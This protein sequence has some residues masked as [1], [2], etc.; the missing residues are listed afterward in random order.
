MEEKV[1]RNLSHILCILCAIALWMYVIYTEDPEMQVWMRGIPI[2]YQGAEAMLENGITFTLTEEPEEVNVKLAGRRSALRRVT[3]NDIHATV[4]YASVRAAGAHTLP[5]Q[6]SLSQ[7]DLRVAKLSQSSVVC[8][9]D[10]LITVDKT[11]S[12]T[13]SGAE[14]FGLSDFAAS[15]STVRITGPKSTLEHLKANVYIDLAEENISNEQTVT[16]TGQSE[17]ETLP[18]SVSIENPTVSIS[19]TRALPIEIEAAN[20]P[21]EGSISEIVCDPK[22]ASVRGSLEELLSAENVRGAYSVWVD[23]SVSPA[24]T[25]P[26]PLLYPEN[27]TVLG[28]ASAKA[29]FY[30]EP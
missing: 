15:P 3:A 1:K 30:T 28:P 4:N 17:K 10:V 7:G 12:I 9:T 27:V 16:L 2:S 22:T 24:I 23:F 13:T 19:A 11:V 18:Q 26:V 6:V 29:E 14:A 5:I 20:S 25:G 21:G 8:E